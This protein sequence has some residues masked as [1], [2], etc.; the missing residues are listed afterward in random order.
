MMTGIVVEYS[1]ILVDFAKS[2]LSAG[3]NHVEAI[4][5]AARIR[6]RPILMTSL[7]TV[8]A[9][10]PMALGLGGGDANIPLARSIIGGVLGAT[11]LSLF[12]VP[13]LF[14]IFRPKV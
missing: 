10:L 7:T 4:L 6:I 13:C 11:L 5:D 3:S 14:V 12:V 1:I 2:R 8:F 9:L